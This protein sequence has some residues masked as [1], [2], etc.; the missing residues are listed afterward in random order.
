MERL[1]DQEA[2]KLSLRNLGSRHITYGVKLHHYKALRDAW[3]IALERMLGDAFTEDLASA[4]NAFD[5]LLQSG[6]TAGEVEST[7]PKGS[8]DA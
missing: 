1:D 5:D 4:W 2:L 3:M 8:I 7:I 6:M